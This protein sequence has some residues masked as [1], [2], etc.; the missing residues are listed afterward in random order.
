MQTYVRK[1][2]HKKCP[3]K[4]ESRF[5]GVSVPSKS[6]IYLLVNKRK[7]KDSLLKKEE[8]KLGVFFKNKY[9]LI[10]WGRAVA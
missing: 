10:V 3:C 8:S 7:K 1:K 5:P 6:T 9:Y 2:Y 4:F